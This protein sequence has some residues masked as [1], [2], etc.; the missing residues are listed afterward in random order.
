[1]RLHSLLYPPNLTYSHCIATVCVQCQ[2]T[3]G[4]FILKCTLILGGYG[5]PTYNNTYLSTCYYLQKNTV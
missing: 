5:S 4:V 2:N 1:M 3:L